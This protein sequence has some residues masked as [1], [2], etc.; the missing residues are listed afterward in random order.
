M[1]KLAFI[2]LVFCFIN[3]LAW[4]Q[5]SIESKASTGSV[6]S[7]L[8]VGY[9]VSIANTSSRSSGL[10]GVS[11]NQN[12]VGNLAN[13]A[14]WG[15]T[16]YGLGAGGIGITSYHASSNNSSVTNL[17]FGVQQF[18]LQLPIIRGVL[19]I[20]GSFAP[21]SET[22]YRNFDFKQQIVSRG[23]TQDTLQYAIENEGSGGTNSAELG[24]GWK[25]NKNLSIGYAA[26]AVFL[27]HNDKYVSNILTSGYN[28]VSY[29]YKTSGVGLGNRFGAHVR[30]PDLFS[31]GDQLGLG[32]AVSLPVSISASQEK[33]S[34]EIIQTLDPI[35]LGEGTIKLPMKVSGGLSYRPNNLI[36]LAAEGLY[37]GWSDYR[38]DL[39]DL[40]QTGT[41]FVDRYKMGL[42]MQYLP[43]RSGSDKF[44][45]KFKYR[46][47]TSFDTGHLQI[48]NKNISTLKFSLGLGIRSP[49]S[50]SSIDLSF[51]Y[52]IRGTNSLNLIK[53]QIW[54]MKLSVNLAEIMF[55]RPK[56]K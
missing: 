32:V 16:V 42:G 35:E 2:A 25:I 44:L 52:G 22:N 5:S 29:T 9:P 48:D 40:S 45:S 12:N 24:I 30:F 46:I 39:E 17:D 37:Q 33:E 51:E 56:L 36:I 8:G 21:V 34:E 43:Y 28:T 1:K 23:T 4:A 38:N 10:L 15:N 3:S 20:S 26:S 11:F 41:S 54:G 19:G 7:K 49:N 55:F 31:E 50:A 18:Q 14:H 47:G 27:S 13:P 6:Y 53:E